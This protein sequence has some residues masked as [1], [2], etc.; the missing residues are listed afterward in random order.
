[1]KNVVNGLI[2]AAI[3]LMALIAEAT[4][5]PAALRQAQDAAQEATTR[6]EDWVQTTAADFEAGASQ[7]IQVTREGNGEL[8]LAAGETT[9][10]FT[11]TVG[12]AAFIFNAVGAHWSADVPPARN[13]LLRCA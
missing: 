9:G 3:L 4:D 11:S 1:M 12:A 6:G 7:G 2:I 13:W 10:I 8:R 5:L